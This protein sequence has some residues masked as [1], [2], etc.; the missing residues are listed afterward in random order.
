MINTMACYLWDYIRK[1]KAVGCFLPLSGGIDSGIT[2]LVIYYLSDRLCQ[3][4]KDGSQH[5]LKEL[6]RIFQDPNFMPEKT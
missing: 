2:A 5:I 6:R 4:V 3:R 1:N